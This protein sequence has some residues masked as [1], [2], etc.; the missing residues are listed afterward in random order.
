MGREKKDLDILWVG[1][2]SQTFRNKTKKKSGEETK[3]LTEPEKKSRK[4]KI[5]LPTSYFTIRGGK[6]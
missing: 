4:F 3:K 2:Q 5:I 1:E 6:F